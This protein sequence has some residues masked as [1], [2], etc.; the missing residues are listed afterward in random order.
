METQSGAHPG[1]CF[2]C[3][4]LLDEWTDAVMC[5]SR[6]ALEISFLDSSAPLRKRKVL[7]DHFHDLKTCANDARQRWND[8]IREHRLQRLAMRAANC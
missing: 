6:V 2:E 3:S 8:H 5:A 4:Q 7:R 1:R